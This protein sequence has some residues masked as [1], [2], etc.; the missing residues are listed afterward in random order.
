MGLRINTNVN[1]LVVQNNLVKSTSRVQNSL[2]KLSSGLRI[3]SPGDDAPGLALATSL[4]SDV[5]SYGQLQRNVEDGLSLVQTAA[6][7][8]QE[9]LTSL[10]RMNELAL[11]AVSGTLTAADRAPL[12]AEFQELYSQIEELQG[13]EFNGQ[14]ILTGSTFAIQ[15]GEG[16]GDTLTIV[17]PDTT[18]GNVTLIDILGVNLNSVSGANDAIVRVGNAT[19][20]L[21]QRLGLLGGTENRLQSVQSSLGTA[22]TNAEA[23]LS[24]VRD[25]DYAQELANLTL[26]QV[27]QEAGVAVLA[28]A[29]TNPQTAIQLLFN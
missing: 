23:A 7:A 17:T 9:M 2:A 3:N 12:D 20:W 29:N 19:N 8:V 10:E 24:R 25:V 6:G 16:V 27:Q 1:S 13:L 28:Q 15:V 4:S 21:T 5:R 26:A 11:Q 14:S 18:H 22:R